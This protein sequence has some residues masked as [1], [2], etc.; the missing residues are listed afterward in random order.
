MENSLDMKVIKRNGRKEDVSFDKI[1]QRIKKI[2]NEKN[3]TLNYVPL[4]I[5]VI[6][7]MYDCITTSQLDE[8]TA[9]QCA[10]MSSIHPEYSVLACNI[11]ISNLH[12]QPSTPP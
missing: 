11:L 2:G 4:A 12:K 9:D 1:L 5:K 8:L 3:L 10:S 6:E 7:Q